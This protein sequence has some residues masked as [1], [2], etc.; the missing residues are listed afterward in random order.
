MLLLH[1]V[2]TLLFLCFEKP[3]KNNFL[4]NNPKTKKF[5]S[6]L[7]N[8]TKTFRTNILHITAHTATPNQNKIISQK[9]NKLLAKLKKIPLKL[10]ATNYSQQTTRKLLTIY[11][12]KKKSLN[13]FFLLLPNVFFNILIHFFL[14]LFFCLPFFIFFIFYHLF[15]H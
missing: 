14:L 11:Y 8:A 3:P 4:P 10:L 6:F 1:N 9:R 2:S 13:F 7:K 12:D 5:F 15:F